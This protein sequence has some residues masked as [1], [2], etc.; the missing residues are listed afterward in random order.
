MWGS[1]VVQ[2]TCR[3]GS[4]RAPLWHDFSK[5]PRPPSHTHPPSVSHVRSKQRTRTPPNFESGTKLYPPSLAVTYVPHLPPFHAGYTRTAPRQGERPGLLRG[6]E[7]IV[8]FT[9][10][11]PIPPLLPA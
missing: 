9:R 6:S 5:Y 2:A 10:E 3:L 4:L 1:G 11:V 7:C 8:R